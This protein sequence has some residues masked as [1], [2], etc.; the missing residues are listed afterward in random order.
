MCIYTPVSLSASNENIASIN[1]FTLLV[2]Q[3]FGA[4]NF[5]HRFPASERFV[6]VLRS[7]ISKFRRLTFWI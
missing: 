1:K 4:Y 5:N 6:D 2:N 7:A 3:I